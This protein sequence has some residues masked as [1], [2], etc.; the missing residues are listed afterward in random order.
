MFNSE[1]KVIWR[2]KEKLKSEN[3]GRFETVT[4]HQDIFSPPSLIIGDEYG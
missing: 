2:E 1:E 3:K 4:E